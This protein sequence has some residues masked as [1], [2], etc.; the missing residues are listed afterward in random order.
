MRQWLQ[1]GLL[2]LDHLKVLEISC[3]QF[4]CSSKNSWELQRPQV[5]L[6]F[7]TICKN[8]F[9]IWRSLSKLPRK[10]LVVV[11]APAFST[12]LITM[13]MWL[14][15]ECMIRGM[16]VYKGG[17]ITN[18]A[19]T[20]TPTPFGDT[21]LFTASAIWRVNRSCTCNLLEYTSAIRANLLS[22]RIFPSG[23]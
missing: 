5:Y 9:R 15:K 23:M 18:V 14:L 4:F 10:V 1:Y 19:S 22:P 16:M 7:N 20:I 13:H 21:N 2:S 6:A 11:L 17:K 8:S 12:P 3:A